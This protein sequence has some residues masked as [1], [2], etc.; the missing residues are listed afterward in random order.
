MINVVTFIFLY[1][2]IATKSS[3]GNHSF[4]P[5]FVGAIVIL[6]IVL[7]LA[8][9]DIASHPIIPRPPLASINQSVLPECSCMY[10]IAISQIFFYRARFSF[11]PT[12]D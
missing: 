4:A 2:S 1:R 3:V 8:A 6:I 11:P 7:A 9:I 5:N 12:R 10:Y